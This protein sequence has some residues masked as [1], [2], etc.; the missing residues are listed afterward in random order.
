MVIEILKRNYDIGL[1][2]SWKRA[3]GGILNE[4]YR[5][6]GP[7]GKYILK[8][9]RYRDNVAELRGLEALMLHFQQRHFPTDHIIYGKDGKPWTQ[10]NGMFYTLHKFVHGQTKDNP[11]DLSLRQARNAM[12][13]LFRYHYLVRDFESKDIGISSVKLPVVYTD[14][15]NRVREFWH[16]ERSLFTSDQFSF[17]LEQLDIINLATKRDSY[18]MLPRL[19]IHGDYKPCNIAFKGEEVSG[20][21]DWDMAQYAPRVYEVVDAAMNLSLDLETLEPITRQEIYRYMELMQ[22]YHALAKG[23]R[24]PLT[25]V[26]KEHVPVMF[27]LKLLLQ[28][29]TFAALLRHLP[30]KDGESISEREERVSRC[31]KR[32]LQL[33]Q[34]AEYSHVLGQL[35]EV[36]KNE[37]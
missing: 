7:N 25:S 10:S 5:I 33:L 34:R 28:G 4:V 29:V 3:S 14:S 23:K 26:E 27:R 24:I 31:L 20:V 18:Q 11:S 36:A 8:G 22:V 37:K 6:E 32:S 35:W 1:I 21:Y 12:Q 9:H 17:A 19:S 2:S 15:L 13:F 30:L 16:K